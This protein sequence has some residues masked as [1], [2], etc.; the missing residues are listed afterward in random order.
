[1]AIPTGYY[2]YRQQLNSLTKLLNEKMPCRRW[3]ISK[4]NRVTN[5]ALCAGDWRV[6]PARTHE[7]VRLSAET[8]PE[9]DALH[10]TDPNLTVFKT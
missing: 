8:T 2:Q 5:R 4:M 9:L 6:D 1:M 7:S 3:L 10:K